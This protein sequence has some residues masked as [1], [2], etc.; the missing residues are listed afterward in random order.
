MDH[1]LFVSET[2][3]RCWR[4]GFVG[5]A[6]LITLDSIAELLNSPASSAIPYRGGDVVPADEYKA[7]A[8][9]INVAWVFNHLK[10]KQSLVLNS[11]DRYSSDV[12]RFARDIHDALP[13]VAASWTNLYI[14]FQEV[15]CLNPHAD[16]T[17]IYVLQLHGTKRWNMSGEVFDLTPGEMLYVPKGE[18]HSA[19]CLTKSS[20]HLTIAIRPFTMQEYLELAGRV[21]QLPEDPIRDAAQVRTYL[22]DFFD[23]LASVNA[24]S[25]IE[26]ARAAPYHFDLSKAEKLD[27]KELL[28]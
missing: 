15:A 11:V 24:E 21:I 22:R 26:Q 7:S 5:H 3:G 9:D 23:Q 20:V 28:R 4:K 19:M 6:G 13:Y 17:E 16:T 1:R 10:S 27:F 8:S 12:A 18:I 14:S 2:I 25:I